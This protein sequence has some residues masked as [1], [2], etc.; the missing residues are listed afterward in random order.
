MRR[1]SPP[2]SNIDHD[3]FRLRFPD[4]VSFLWEL[5]RDHRVVASRRLSFA[6][7]E[8]V[9]LVRQTEQ[10]TFLFCSENA[11]SNLVHEADWETGARVLFEVPKGVPADSMVKAVRV[12]ADVITVSTGYAASLLR[13]DTERKQVLLTIGGREQL[14]PEQCQRPLSPFFF[15]G[16]QM[17]ENGDYLLSNWQ[18]HSAAKNS[19]GYQLLRYDAM[20]R[21]LWAFDQTAHPNLSSLNNVLALDGLDTRKLHDEPRG[22][23][24]PLG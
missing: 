23:L 10:G 4:L 16:Y 17:F 24:V 9:R 6:G 20:G 21:L 12:S 7:I 22:V 14:N 2:K 13:I 11:G 15:S 19:Q 5:D 8:K 1:G 18:G 3:I